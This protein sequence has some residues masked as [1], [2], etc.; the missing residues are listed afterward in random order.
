MK[1]KLYDK[2]YKT[3]YKIYC[4]VQLIVLYSRYKLI[5]SWK[6]NV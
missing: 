6:L 2:I 4:N 5:E 3:K 1:N